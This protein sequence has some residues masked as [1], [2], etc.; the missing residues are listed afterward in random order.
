M[1]PGFRRDD[2]GGGGLVGAGEAK[3]GNGQ[4]NPLGIVTL[5][6]VDLPVTLPLFQVLLARDRGF[7]V[8][9]GFQPHQQLNAI[10]AREARHS[11]RAVFIYAP[12]QIGG[13]ADVN[14]PMFPTCVDVDVSTHAVCSATA[15]PPAPAPN[16]S[17]CPCR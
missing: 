11:V 2:G 3:Q 4:V 16:R 10:S 6:Q 9:L 8:L 12:E 1:G 7:D 5:D 15:P 13:N 17:C 14:R